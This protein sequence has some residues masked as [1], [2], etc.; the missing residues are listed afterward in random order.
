MIVAH[1]LV[2]SFVTLPSIRLPPRPS[3]ANHHPASPH[4]LSIR[5]PGE[6]GLRAE[7][8]KNRDLA[9]ESSRIERFAQSERLPVKGEDRS[10]GLNEA[11]DLNHGKGLTMTVLTTDVLAPAELLDND[12]LGAELV[13]DFTGNL[14]TFDGRQTDFRRAVFQGDEQNGGKDEF[15]AGFT[16][17]AI[18]PDP[19]TFT[20]AELMA[21]FLDDRVHPSKTPQPGLPPSYCVPGARRLTQFISRVQGVSLLIKW[22]QVACVIDCS[23]NNHLNVSPAKREE[24]A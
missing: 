16:L 20:D 19:V 1:S 11:R 6:N 15:V 2:L 14:G 8:Q 17:A 3:T 10:L 13:D 24:P 21:A 18:D 23:I 5:D 7:K 12:L 22:F 9:T 4:I